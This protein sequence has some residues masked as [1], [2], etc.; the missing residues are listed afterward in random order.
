L[1]RSRSK[2]LWN[3][4]RVERPV[5]VFRASRPA[6][7]R[8]ERS[9]SESDGQGAEAAARAA[10]R[11]ALKPYRKSAHGPSR[12]PSRHRVGGLLGGRFQHVR[13]PS[14]WKCF[15][16]RHDYVQD[17]PD[18]PRGGPP[19]TTRTCPLREKARPG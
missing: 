14:K 18:R 13:K 15:F 12:H 9:V 17:R 5:L 7:A 6:L 11:A 1:F 8:P 10:R 3:L 19:P 16:G 4:L 2:F